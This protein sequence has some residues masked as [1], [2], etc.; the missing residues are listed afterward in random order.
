MRKTVYLKLI[1]MLEYLPDNIGIV[2]EA[3]RPLEI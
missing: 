1:K 3:C 2:V